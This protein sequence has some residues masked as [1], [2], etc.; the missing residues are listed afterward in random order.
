MAF[1]P[2][3]L[4]GLG[5][6]SGYRRARAERQAEEEAAK[7][8]QARADSRQAQRQES[9]SIFRNLVM[10]PTDPVHANMDPNLL[11]AHT[12]GLTQEDAD[13]R[14]AAASALKPPP[15]FDDAM[16]QAWEQAST[17]G[18]AERAMRL[19]NTF[20]S[21][22]PVPGSSDARAYRL[23]DEHGNLRTFKGTPQQMVEE[24]ERV[25]AA[26]D[27][28][29]AAAE[30]AA[31]RPARAHRPWTPIPQARTQIPADPPEMTMSLDPSS[32]TPSALQP[33][34]LTSSPAPSTPSVA[35]AS[36]SQVREAVQRAFGSLPV[37]QA[38]AVAAQQ[39][40]ALAPSYPPS[41]L[42]PIA[43]GRDGQGR[44][45]LLPGPDGHPLLAPRAL[46]AELGPWLSRLLARR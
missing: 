36:L 7:A 25:Q 12:P 6:Y 46:A 45:V 24:T 22:K 4:L 27:E 17:Q 8:R 41:E 3:L 32:A 14:T 40:A 23:P 26:Q 19:L 2:L 1:I 13:A 30:A 39:L 34:D 21:G 35:P 9:T 20:Y 10:Q 5:G 33:P 31:S 15:A 38:V 16:S 44:P 28:A 29:E 18:A 42:S 37:E 11:M 43:V